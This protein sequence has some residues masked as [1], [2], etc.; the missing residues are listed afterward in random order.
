[1]KKDIVDLIKAQGNQACVMMPDIMDIP[2]I[3]LGDLVPKEGI[4]ELK[5]DQKQRLIAF[6]DKHKNSGRFWLEFANGDIRFKILMTQTELT[7]KFSDE[8]YAYASSPI[9]ETFGDTVTITIYVITLAKIEET[10]DLIFGVKTL[11]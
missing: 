4:N 11:K 6:L 3:D 10:Q 1:M 2:A 8:I 5:A 9:N 7:T